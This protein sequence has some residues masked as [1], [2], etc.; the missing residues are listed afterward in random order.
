MRR[1]GRGVARKVVVADKINVEDQL[2]ALEREYRSQFQLRLVEN[3]TKPAS[4]ASSKKVEDVLV[5]CA[6]PCRVSDYTQPGWEWKVWSSMSAKCRSNV[7]KK[8]RNATE[9]GKQKCHTMKSQLV[10]WETRLFVQRS[11]RAELTTSSYSSAVVCRLS[12]RS[13]AYSRPGFINFLTGLVSPPQT[14]AAR[15]TTQPSTSSTAS[16]SDSSSRFFRIFGVTAIAE[17]DLY[18]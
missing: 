2:V 18:A 8:A 13:C 12:H 4:V 16:S 9:S 15:K 11:L 10:N 7:R 3:C 1:D 14:P 6:V 17:S 5:K